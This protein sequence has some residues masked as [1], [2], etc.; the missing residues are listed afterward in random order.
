MG[1]LGTSTYVETLKSYAYGVAQDVKTT[2]ADFI[3]PRVPVG[4]GSGQFKKFSDKNAF[5]VETNDVHAHSSHRVFSARAHCARASM[6]KLLIPC[7]ALATYGQK[8]VPDLSRQRGVSNIAPT[9][10]AGSTTR[11]IFQD[12]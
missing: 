4:V 6:C 8:L 1:K 5:Q 9:R 7:N 3:A 11:R 10:H 12:A 2:L